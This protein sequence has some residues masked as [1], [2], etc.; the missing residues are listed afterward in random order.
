MMFIRV[1]IH[2]LQIAKDFFKLFENTMVLGKR[3]YHLGFLLKLS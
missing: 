2:H 3:M 1:H